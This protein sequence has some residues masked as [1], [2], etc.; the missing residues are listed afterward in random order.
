MHNRKMRTK[1]YARPTPSPQSVPY[2]EIRDNSQQPEDNEHV[3]Y[4]YHVM[5]REKTVHIL[6]RG[7]TT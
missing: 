6:E 5:Q 2:L 3:D 4:P 1:L 7:V